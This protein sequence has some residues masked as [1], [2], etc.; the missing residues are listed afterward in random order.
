MNKR[1]VAG[2]PSRLRQGFVFR[3]TNASVDGIVSA[4]THAGS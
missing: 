3:A 2:A 4:T 1:V